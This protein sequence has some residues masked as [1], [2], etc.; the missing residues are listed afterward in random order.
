MHNESPASILLTSDLTSQG[1]LNLLTC[2][3]ADTSSST[4]TAP[5]WKSIARA[6]SVSVPNVETHDSQRVSLSATSHTLAMR[7]LKLKYKNRLAVKQQEIDALKL[8]LAL[9]RHR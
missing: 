2:Y 6:G 8:A 9:A 7:S 5:E 4:P 3:G 1:L